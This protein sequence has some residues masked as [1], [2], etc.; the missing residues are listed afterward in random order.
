MTDFSYNSD[1]TGGS[2]MV[3]ESRIIAG[4]LLKKAS[5]E[6][7]TDAIQVENLLQKKSP[8][9]AK[10]NVQAIRKR[11]ER[12]EPEFWRALRDG[13][14]E[15]ATQ[16]AFCAALERNLL[17]VEFMERVVQDA[18]VTRAESLELYQWND[19]LEDCA[20][21]DPI[22][23]DWKESSKKKMG[24]VAFRMLA[25]MGYINNT[26]SLKLQ[27]VLIRSEVRVMLEDTY[28]LRIKDCMDVS[29]KGGR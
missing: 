29:S 4:L 16:V 23:H 19:F 8:A 13:D 20:H 27:N 1:L 2:L 26:R 6:E 28:K 21:K 10:R 15:L 17:L 18:Y 22:I 11:L 14:D 12:L 24:Q 25:E 5:A 9:S 3:R 7:W